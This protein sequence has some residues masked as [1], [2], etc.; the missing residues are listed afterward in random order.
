MKMCDSGHQKILYDEKESTDGTDCPLCHI[1][2]EIINLQ[3][4][5]SNN[6]TL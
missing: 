1:L 2:N 6:E 4:E 3:E 5:I